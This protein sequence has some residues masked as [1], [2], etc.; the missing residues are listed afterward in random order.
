MHLGTLGEGL[1]L[2][3]QMLAVFP[4]VVQLPLEHVALLSQLLDLA[5][6]Q[7]NFAL[8]LVVDRHAGVDPIEQARLLLEGAVL[9]LELLELVVKPRDLLLCLELEPSLG[10]ETLAQHVLRTPEC[11]RVGRAARGRQIERLSPRGDGRQG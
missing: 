10:L 7:V 9:L 4:L 11:K 1:Q 3:G 2:D 5:P 8:A 6:G